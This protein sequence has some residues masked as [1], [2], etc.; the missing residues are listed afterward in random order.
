M[1]GFTL[2]ELIVVISAIAILAGMIAPTIGNLVD[3]AKLNKMEVEMNSIATAATMYDKDAGNIPF[4]N[5]TTITSLAPATTS[6]NID[7]LMNYT[8]NVTKNGQVITYNFRDK[9]DK[10]I[11]FD[12]WNFTYGYWEAWTVPAWT[13]GPAGAVAS[14][15]ADRLNGPGTQEWNSTTWRNKTLLANNN[16]GSYKV[17][18]SNI[19]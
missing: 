12:P 8:Q 10:R 16:K 3:D 1:R 13:P 19:Q 11:Q 6:A 5:N 4:G 2:I 9:L 14:Y 7:Q 17:F 18:K 15:G